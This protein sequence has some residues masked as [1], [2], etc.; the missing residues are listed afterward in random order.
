M[1]AIIVLLT[2]MKTAAVMQMIDFCFGLS[3]SCILGYHVFGLSDAIGS[4]HVIVY[5]F[6]KSL[7]PV[8]LLF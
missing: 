4:S 2:N 3:C 8:L 5:V 6:L 7:L 1:A